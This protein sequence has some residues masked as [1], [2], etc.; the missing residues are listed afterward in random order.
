MFKCLKLSERVCK[1]MPG[2]AR[3]YS[4]SPLGQRAWQCRHFGILGSARAG[5]REYFS[6]HYRHLVSPRRSILY[7]QKVTHGPW[8]RKISCITCRLH[9]AKQQRGINTL[10]GKS[11][12]ACFNARK[13]GQT[14]RLLGLTLHFVYLAQRLILLHH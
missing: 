9:V 10:G 1:V 8:D 12:R 5:L 11:I 3:G 2:V 13:W 6:D 14:E 7:H 4:A